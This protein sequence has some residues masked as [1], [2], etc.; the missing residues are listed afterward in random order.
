MK[1]PRDHQSTALP[2]DPPA[3]TSG[4]M[5]SWVPTKERDRAVTGSATKNSLL[6]ATVC[7]FFDRKKRWNRQERGV[8]GGREERLFWGG[9]GSGDDDGDSTAAMASEQSERSKSDSMM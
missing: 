5:Y 6:G 4:D 1:I 9:V 7:I 2:W 8:E 3:A